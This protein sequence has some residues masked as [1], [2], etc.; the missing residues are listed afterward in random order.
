MISGN[1]DNNTDIIFIIYNYYYY[2][3]MNYHG[4]SKNDCNSTSNV[5]VLTYIYSVAHPHTILTCIY[6]VVRAYKNVMIMH[7]AIY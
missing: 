7:L 1:L 4:L 6:C 2:H 5:Q 3:A